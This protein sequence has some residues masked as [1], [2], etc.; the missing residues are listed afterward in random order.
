MSIKIAFDVQGFENDLIHAITAARNFVKNNDKIEIILVGDEIK[1]KE[2]FKKPNEFKIVNAPETITQDDT[3]LS[4]RFKKNT[5]MHKAIQL[6]KN[7]EADGVLSAGNSAVYVFLTYQSFGLINGINKIGFI[8][9]VPTFKGTGFNIVDVGASIN[10]QEDDI[11]NFALMGNVAAKTRGIKKP[12]IGLLN[13][14]VEEHKGFE[15]HHNLNQRLKEN[16]N[17]NYIGFVESKNLLDGICDV[18]VCDGYTGNVLLKT[19][20]GTSKSIMYYLLS[21]YKKWYNIFGLVF[22]LPV[23]L[24]F[25]KKFDYKNNAGAFVLGVNKIAV[26]THGSADVK[27]FY[28]ALSLLKESIE[29]QLLEKLKKELE[30]SDK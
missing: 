26:K 22:S 3:I 2:F 25:K 24:A 14:G 27:Q 29:F 8:P 28:S 12:K 13:I 16:K 7:N 19:L 20:E 1:I 17:I 11:Y 5:S 4:L 18:V 15:W 23:L 30:D 10:C 6:V 21:K 9:Y